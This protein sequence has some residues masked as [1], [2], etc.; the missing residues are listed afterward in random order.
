MEECC[1]VS[2]LCLY[3]RCLR[4]IYNSNLICCGLVSVKVYN[5][6]LVYYGVHILFTLQ[7]FFNYCISKPLNLEML[8]CLAYCCLTV[9]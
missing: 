6:F 3:A 7:S 5:I 9:V 1:L 4:Y 8:T 2:K